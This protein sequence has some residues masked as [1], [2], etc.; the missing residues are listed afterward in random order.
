VIDL[1][2]MYRLMSKYSCIIDDHVLICMDAMYQMDELQSGPFMVGP[3]T[4]E[5]RMKP[6]LYG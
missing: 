3:F 4:V 6:R 5:A 2:L 1:S